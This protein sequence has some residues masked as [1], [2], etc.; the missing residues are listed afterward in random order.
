EPVR[1]GRNRPD[2]VHLEWE[3][4]D[5]DVGPRGAIFPFLIHDFTPREQR[6]FPQGKPS[7]RDFGGL[8]RVVIAV[9]DLDATIRLYR[10]AFPGPAPRKQVD[11]P[12]GANL[13]MLEGLPVV[14]AQ[15]I[16]QDSW[17]AARLDRFGEAPCA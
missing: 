9:K 5:I 2:G 6:A 13:A 1:N 10:Q 7:T 11:R 3:T 16:A 12:F 8:T 14:L 15:P 4:A 17:L